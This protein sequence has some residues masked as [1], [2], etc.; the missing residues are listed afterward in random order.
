V[1]MCIHLS[2]YNCNTYFYYTYINT[3]VLII[4]TI[5]DTYVLLM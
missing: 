5:D 3:Y 4:H 2:T 1:F